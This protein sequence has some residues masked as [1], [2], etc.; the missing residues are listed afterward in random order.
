M[1]PPPPPLPP[2]LSSPA[3]CPLS[4]VQVEWSIYRRNAE[5]EMIPLLRELGIGIVAYN[6]L[7]RDTLPKVPANEEEVKSSLQS[8]G[9]LWSTGTSVAEDDPG[10]TEAISA[11]VRCP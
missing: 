8:G 6:P 11:K 10:I 4:A 2:P 9:Q 1:I 7:G 5:K 3:V